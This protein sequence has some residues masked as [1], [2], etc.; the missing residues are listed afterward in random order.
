M[1]LSQPE[2][3]AHG[4]GTELVAVLEVGGAERVASVCTVI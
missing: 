2:E 3:A 4:C 1:G